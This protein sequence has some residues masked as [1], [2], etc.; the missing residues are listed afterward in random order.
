MV[1]DTYWQTETGS[2]PGSATLPF[3]GIDVAILDPAT[4]RELTGNNVTGVLAI[5]KPFPSM[6]RTV[7]NNHK[8]FLDTYLKPYHGY[9]FTGDGA[10]RDQDGFIWIEGRLDD[11]I[12]VAGHRL[13]TAEIEAALILHPACAEAAVVGV[14]H[15]VTGQ[16]IVCYVTLKSHGD[17]QALE[18]AFVGQVRAHI[19]PFATPQRITRSGK[20]MRR[21]LRKIAA[22]EVVLAD[23]SDDESLR[24]K[25]GDLSTLADPS[26]V[27]H[28]LEKF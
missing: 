25:L 1:V 10:T 9:Y 6:A 4:G 11:V 18:K 19:G 26:I 28:L 27:K 12:N 2:H 14:P 20:I 15:D 7:Y 17:L 8:R 21:I 23:A 24:N 16:A 13:S 3:F 5:R 22:K